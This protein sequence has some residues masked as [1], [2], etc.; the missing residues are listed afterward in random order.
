MIKG[1]ITAG[2]ETSGSLLYHLEDRS[3][4]FYKP[5]DN[6]YEMNS[7]QTIPFNIF[8]TGNMAFIAT[9]LGK[10]GL[11]SW[12]CYICKKNPITRFNVLSLRADVSIPKTHTMALLHLQFEICNMAGKGS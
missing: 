8:M 9:C 1:H 10:E 11:A 7:F 4:E 2:T 6:Q 12:H 3:L 5:D